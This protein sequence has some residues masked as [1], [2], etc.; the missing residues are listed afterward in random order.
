MTKNIL[1]V[2]LITISGLELSSQDIDIDQDQS[3]SFDRDANSQGLVKLG[4]HFISQDYD[5]LKPELGDYNV[6]LLNRQIGAV[7]LGFGAQINK[8]YYAMNLDY[9]AGLEQDHDSLLSIAGTF[10]LGLNYGYNILDT[11]RWWI[12]P[13]VSVIGLMD[14]LISTAED[15]RVPLT[16]YVESP[17]LDMRMLQF[18]GTIGLHTG[19]KMG[20]N[21]LFNGYF[22]L[23]GYGGYAFELNK[24]PLIY[25]AYN[26]L[27]TNKEVK[28]EPLAFGLYFAVVFGDDED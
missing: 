22:M 14:R 26:R 25:N 9:M 2:I 13:E 1:F 7:R 18:A 20:V 15:R 24:K 6:D 28:I 16:Q 12:T 21:R 17:S 5:A 3:I 19:Y 11:K 4:G 23:G 27:T 10:N 8:S